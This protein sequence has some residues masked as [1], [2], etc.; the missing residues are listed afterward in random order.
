MVAQDYGN[1][2]PQ[3]TLSK[4]FGKNTTQHASYI[5]S[6]DTMAIRVL[7]VTHFINHLSC[8]SY[9]THYLKTCNNFSVCIIL[10]IQLVAP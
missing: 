6:M 4:Y 5:K 7:S 10:G 8:M 3:S 2:L 9:N 1:E